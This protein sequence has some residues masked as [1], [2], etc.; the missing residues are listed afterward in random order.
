MSLVDTR[1]VV[2]KIR[3]FVTIHVAAAASDDDDD[4]DDN[5]NKENSHYIR[6]PLNYTPTGP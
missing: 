6:E 1:T 2:A 3:E 4:N 5:N